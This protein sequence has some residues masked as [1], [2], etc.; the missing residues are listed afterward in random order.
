[1]SNK[2]FHSSLS[3]INPV[4]FRIEIKET[5]NGNI[6]FAILPKGKTSFYFASEYRYLDVNMVTQKLST[7]CSKI[8]FEN[9][10]FTL[11]DGWKMRFD[12]DVELH[13]I[14]IASKKFIDFFIAEILQ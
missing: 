7:L 13:G 3:N 8:N 11:L 5:K 2:T 4:R 12:S 10:R 6:H 9:G 1:M 14:K